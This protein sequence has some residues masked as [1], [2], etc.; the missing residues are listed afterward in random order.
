MA[1]VLDEFVA[2]HLKRPWQPGKVDCLLALADWCIWRGYSD[3]AADL[4][5]SYDSEA[6]FRAIIER[7]GGV[8]PLV[9]GCTDLLGLARAD[10]PVP[11]AIAI[12]GSRSNIQRQWG[13]IYDGDATGWRVRFVDAYPVLKARPLAIWNL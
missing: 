3:A 9:T 1:G 10:Q 13:A 8:I 11:G 12:V 6:G 7:A 5:G 2:E 4:R